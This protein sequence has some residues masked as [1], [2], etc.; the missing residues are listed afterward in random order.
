MVGC[1][2][3]VFSWVCLVV[4]LRIVVVLLMMVCVFVGFA[5][6]FDCSFYVV[7]VFV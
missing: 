4:G 7:L 1:V 2:G 3:G 6:A 5:D